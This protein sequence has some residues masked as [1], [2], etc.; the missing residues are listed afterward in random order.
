MPYL[1]PD[2]LLALIESTSN[3]LLNLVERDLGPGVELGEF[4][5][6]FPVMVTIQMDHHVRVEP[7]QRNEKRSLL[8]S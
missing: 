7:I 4:N 2:T 1:P 6:Q 8:F 5:M 3:V